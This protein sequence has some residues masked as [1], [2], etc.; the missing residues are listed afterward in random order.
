M[1]LVDAPLHVD[2]V[3]AH[4]IVHL[5]AEDIHLRRNHVDVAQVIVE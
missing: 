2:A 5:I 3:V 1:A 4:R